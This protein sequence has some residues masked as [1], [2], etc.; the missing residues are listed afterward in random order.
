MALA[1]FMAKPIGRLIRVIAGLALILVGV[2]V[3]EGT[4]GWL[5]ALVGVLPLVT[6]ALNVCLISPLLGAPFSGKKA[7][8][9]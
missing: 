1:K 8:E 7:L 4:E 3:V 5:L 6:G 9:S 2:L